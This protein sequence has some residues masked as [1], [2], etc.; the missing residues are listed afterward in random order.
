M[1]QH[2][3]IVLHLGDGNVFR[4]D[5]PLRHRDSQVLLHLVRPLPGTM[6]GPSRS[7]GVNEGAADHH[8]RCRAS[9]GGRHGERHP[10]GQGQER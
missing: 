5:R 8:L 2:T 9:G 7:D 6:P 3:P 10:G 1:Y 4:V